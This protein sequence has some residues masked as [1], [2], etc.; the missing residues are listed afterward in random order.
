MMTLHTIHCTL[1]L[2]ITWKITIIISDMPINVLQ[3]NS[4]IVMV[5][6][7]L[8]FAMNVIYKCHPQI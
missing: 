1:M 4:N 5:Y 8:E 3:G 7:H 2:K 6:M